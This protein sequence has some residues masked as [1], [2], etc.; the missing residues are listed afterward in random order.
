MGNKILLIGPLPN[1]RNKKS[2]GGATIL[3]KV[4]VGYCDDNKI[5]YELVITN[6]YSGTFSSIKN[7]SSIL[8]NVFSKVFFCKFVFCNVSAN[9]A[10]FLGPFCLILSLILRKK[11][12]F[13]LFGSWVL[14]ILNSRSVGSLLLKFPIKYSDMVAMESNYIISHCKHIKSDIYWL[15]NS[16]ILPETNC[17]ITFKEFKGK[18]I[19]LSQIKQVKGID[20]FLELIN[21]SDLTDYV[22]DVYGPIIDEE[23]KFLEEKGFYKGVLKENDVFSILKNYDVLILPTYYEGEGYPGI[24]IEAYMCALPV[25]ASNWK[26]IPEIVKDG[27]TGFLVNPHDY[28]GLKEKVLE[29]SNDNYNSFS[30]NSLFLGREFSSKIVHDKLFNKVYSI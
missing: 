28:Q 13:R 23:Y 3:F 10:K 11:F 4:L 9:G 17:N 12:V 1:V 21:D 18:F 15:P 20:L 6:K 8:K 5:D 25:I 16:R 19:F 14:D 7:I 2:Y 29:F 24:I 22:F 30:E 27:E 26:A